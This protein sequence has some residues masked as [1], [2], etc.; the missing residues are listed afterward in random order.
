MVALA[1]WKCGTKFSDDEGEG[2]GWGMDD[3]WLMETMD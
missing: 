2:E 1:Q 3:F